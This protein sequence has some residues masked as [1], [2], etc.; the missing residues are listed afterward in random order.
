MKKSVL[1]FV[2]FFIIYLTC[3]TK[4]PVVKEEI[5]E[6]KEEAEEV[7]VELEP[8]AILK[9]D[10]VISPPKW[11]I[12]KIDY[13]ALLPSELR[14]I[15]SL[16]ISL[17]E[18][19][20][21]WRVQIGNF[22]EVEHAIE[23]S[24]KAGS[25]ME[26]IVYLDFDAPFHKVRVGDCSTRKNAQALLDKMKRLGFPDAFLIPTMVYKYPE[27]RRQTEEEGKKA[28]ADTL[29]IE[30]QIKRDFQGDIKR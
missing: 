13:D 24:D 5:E 8:L 12:K 7:T 17:D 28:E 26:E 10:V 4:E 16:K 11:E 22:R 15:D 21:G 3:A 30:Q 25:L 14:P 18:M 27:L 6:E 1:F 29:N 9:D 19:T 2:L 23:I 20:Q